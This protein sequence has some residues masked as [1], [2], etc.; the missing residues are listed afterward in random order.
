MTAS[1]AK[2]YRI[3][4]RSVIP[5]RQRWDVAALLN[6]PQ[7]AKFV[8]TRL[9]QQSGIGVVR[10]N[11]VTGRLL[12]F[13]DTEL[14]GEEVGQLVRKTAAQVSLQALV[15][16]IRRSSRFATSAATPTTLRRSDRGAVTLAVVG[17]GLV[18]LSLRSPMVRLGAVLGATVT[19]IWR[20]W[21]R[22]KQTQLASAAAHE[23]AVGAIR[24]ILGTHSREFSRASVLS[25]LAQVLYAVPYLSM[26]GMLAVLTKG[27]TAPLIRL[28]LRGSA[29]Q[30]WFLAGTTLVVFVTFAGVSFTANMM[31]RDLAQ[32]VQHE[33]RNEMYAHVQWSKLRYLEAERMTRLAEALTGDIDQL[34]RFLAGPANALLQIATCFVV[35]AGAFLFWAPH[36]AWIVFLPAPIIAWL[37]FSHQERVAPKHATSSETRSLLNSQLINNLEASA[38]VKSFGAENYEI[39]RIMRLS[40]AYRQS[41]HQSDTHTLAYNHT[42]QAFA[43]SAMFGVLLFGGLDVLTGT[44]ALEAYNGLVGL[45]MLLLMR[46]PELGDA[47]EQY[48][49]TVAA[50]GRV[51]E[52]R[53]LPVEPGGTG[54]HLDLATVNGEIV[55]D[56]VTFAY[57]E[58]PPVLRDF[59]LRMLAR[60]TTGIVGV[61]GAGKTTIAKLMLRLQ[62]V[63]SGRVL[64]DGADLRDLRLEDLR[65][66]ISFVAQDAFLFD[67]SIGDNIQYGSFDADFVS[68][69]NAARLAKAAD[70]VEA[71][72]SQYD[73]MIGE[74]GVT[75]SGGQK[76]RLSL[77][78][79]IL[80]NAPIL[81]LDEA[82]SAV[83]NETEAA[84]QSALADF[85]RDRTLLIIA[86]RLSTIRHADW[87]YV[88]G[89]GGMV[90]E[91]GTHQELLERDGVY[92]SLWRLQ[93]GDAMT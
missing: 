24:Q 4:P 78:R 37:S 88:I 35:V 16:P 90:V 62:D 41:N 45:P 66:A 51:L 32:T 39:A 38:T 31:W 52:L 53:R 82:T 72:P 86:H 64:L 74:R 12:V 2:S 67:G 85:A 61:T 22:S 57:P 69:T 15:I 6:R 79:A 40:E 55:F 91:E 60:Q 20:G 48:L 7:V 14:S 73:T 75:L 21:R 56:S 13:H 19:I 47:V 77:A 65:S 36:I 54:R 93:I 70:F 84:I 87:I 80:K 81:I 10:A 29:S 49:R 92:A 76:Q 8:E 18:A 25:V 46:L 68:V 17:G 63:E 5:G 9:Q 83:D 89:R 43:L 44:L 71:L 11:P 42:V 33:W 23:S 50:L 3:E 59:S 34:S 58:R 28:G 30:L 27:P 26:A 1:F